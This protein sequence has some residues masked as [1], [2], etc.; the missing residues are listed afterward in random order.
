MYQIIHNKDTINNGIVLKRILIDGKVGYRLLS[1]PDT[2]H[3]EIGNGSIDL[4]IQTQVS[5]NDIAGDYSISLGLNTIATNYAQTVIG[6]NNENRTDAL[7]EVGNG[8]NPFSRSNALTILKDGKTEISGDFYSDGQI[9]AATSFKAGIGASGSS[10]IGFTNTA[11]TIA[12]PAIFWNNDLKEFQVDDDNGLN[13]RLLHDGNINTIIGQL[14]KITENGKTGYR[15]RDRNNDLYGDIGSDAIDLSYSNISGDLGSIGDYSF[16]TGYNT[17]A[18]NNSSFVF[19]K[20]NVGTDTNTI[21]EVGIGSSNIDRKNG[22]E[23]YTDGTLNTP[24]STVDKIN[25]RGNKTLV[26]KEYVDGSNVIGETGSTSYSPNFNIGNYFEY[27]IDQNVT[28]DNPQNF[29]KGDKGYLI[30]IQD[31]NGNR[32]VSW[33]SNWIFP[34]GVPDIGQ[35]ANDINIF[36]YIVVSQDKIY[37]EFKATV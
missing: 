35:V 13:Q 15:L 34:N 32:S 7:F 6:K 22:L 11:G 18:L 14:E 36:E 28:I 27:T 10:V 29:E 5:T 19:G 3:P 17:I 12:L 30:I 9:T 24:E 8:S 37:V 25:S 2:N 26:T 31:S 1:E 4:S 23:I 33:G 20:Y 21:L 16:A